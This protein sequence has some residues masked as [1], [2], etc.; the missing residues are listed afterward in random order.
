MPLSEAYAGRS[1]A[2]VSRQ[3]I[4]QERFV[5]HRACLSRPATLLRTSFLPVRRTACFCSRFAAHGEEQ[6]QPVTAEQG[7]SNVS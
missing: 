4:N 1:A 2:P 7:F 5:T 3:N 6:K